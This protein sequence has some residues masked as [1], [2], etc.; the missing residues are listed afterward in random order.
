[1]SFDCVAMAQQLHNLGDVT[2][3][4][5]VVAMQIQDTKPDLNVKGNEKEFRKLA[6]F[7]GGWVV[8]AWRG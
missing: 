7:Y 2:V 6:K 4:L 3:S 5:P 1:M 8:V